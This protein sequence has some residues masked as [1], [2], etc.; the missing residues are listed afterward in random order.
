MNTAYSQEED[1]NLQYYYFLIIKKEFK[2]EL[3][4]T[5]N[6]FFIK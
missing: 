2:L 4:L 5:I 6:Q 1:E 3:N